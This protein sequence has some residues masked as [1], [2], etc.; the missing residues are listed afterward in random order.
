[1]KGRL[2]KI[3]SVVFLALGF[4]VL[5]SCKSRRF[6]AA[7]TNAWE[8]P[9]FRQQAIQD[10]VTVCKECM[11]KLTATPSS[12][13]PKAP[14]DQN[15][16]EVA[17]AFAARVLEDKNERIPAGV[18]GSSD[19]PTQ[20]NSTP[21]EFHYNEFKKNPDD[22][23]EFQLATCVRFL[24][25]INLAQLSNK[26]ETALRLMDVNEQANMSAR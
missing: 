13:L 2:V 1:M 16:T 15:V 4:V 19:S 17:A 6:T 26:S 25:S 7:K 21:L 3:R 8:Q 18:A 22:A 10:I 14:S 11:N 24:G 12:K 20:K 23:A 5:A 9:E